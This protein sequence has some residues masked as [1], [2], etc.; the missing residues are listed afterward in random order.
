MEEQYDYVMQELQHDLPITVVLTHGVGPV[1]AMEEMQVV[2]QTKAT[3]ET[4]R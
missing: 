3:V 1:K 2:V 4:L